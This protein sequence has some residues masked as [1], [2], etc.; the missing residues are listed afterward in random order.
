MSYE[1]SH[2]K[3]P[4]QGRWPDATPQ[5]GWPAYPRGDHAIAGYRAQPGYPQAGAADATAGPGHGYAWPGNGY[6]G[7]ADG[8]PGTAD[9]FDGGMSRHPWDANGYADAG[10]GYGD[11]LDG[12]GGVRDDFPGSA[13]YLEPDRYTPPRSPGPLLIAPDTAGEPG[14]PSD[15]SGDS[16][17]EAGR[18]GLI[19]GAITGFLAAA[20][21]IGVSTLAAAFVRPQASPVIAV[22]GAVIDRTPSSLKNFAVEHFGENDKTILLLGMYVTLALIAIAIGCLARREVTIGVAG[23]ALFGLFGAFVAITRPESRLT[24]VIP[25]AIGG[26]AG[27]AA[28]AWLART[29]APAAPLRHA[30]GSSRWKPR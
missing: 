12:G 18:Y 27:V 9:G 1:P 28:F 20:V 13:D 23:I 15:P 7:A 21:A 14:W 4:R 11:A 5:E 26:I 17:R 24:D 30:H 16:G 8:Y 29:A 22:G 25:S 6:P 19:V 2:R 3:P 10:A